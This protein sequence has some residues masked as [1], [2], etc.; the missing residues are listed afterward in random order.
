MKRIACL[1]LLILLLPATAPAAESLD[2]LRSEIQSFLKSP[3]SEFAP[4]TGERAQA[5]LG[6]AMLA[7]QHHNETELKSSIEAASQALANARQLAERFRKKYADLLS[8]RQAAREAAGISGDPK[9]KDAEVAFHKMIA[10]VEEGQLNDSAQLSSRAAAG[11]NSVI[12]AALPH[13]LE[14]TSDAI[15]RAAAAG[16]RYYAPQTYE[17]AKAWFARTQAYVDGVGKQRPVH[18]RLGLKLAQYA[19][20]IALQVKQFRRDRGSHEKLMLDAKADRLRL[21]DALGISYDH[22]DPQADVKVATLVDRIGEL[23]S[24]LKQAKTDADK[25]AAELKAQYEKQLQERLQQQ[26]EQLTAANQ[27]QV[28]DLKDAFQAK[29]KR[30]TFE[31]RRQT[32]VRKLFDKNDVKISANLDGS[33]LIRLTGLHFATGESSIDHKYYDLLSHLKQALEVYSDRDI[34]IEGHTDNKGDAKLNQKLSLKRAEAV[35]DFLIAA[36]VPGNRLK[37]LGYGEV[38]PIA[39]ND[40]AKGRAMNRRIDVVIQAPHG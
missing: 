39:S 28:E 19:R 16:A 12:N 7:Q 3:A 33:L 36:G 20:E 15:S 27:K 22:D 31:S 34:R 38:R 23:V 4:D 24:S 11:Y 6:S 13:L 1:L 14:R 18:P 10:A 5:L 17:K 30:E 37:A 21:A 29:L 2:A 25:Q 40:Y 8:L 35:R 9:L 26:K 32:R